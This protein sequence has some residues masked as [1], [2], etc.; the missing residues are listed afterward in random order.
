MNSAS[1][2]SFPKE[3]KLQQFNVYVAVPSLCGSA[4]SNAVA[5]GQALNQIKVISNEG[6]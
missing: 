6:Y 4:N 1:W 5:Q 3:F 2:D